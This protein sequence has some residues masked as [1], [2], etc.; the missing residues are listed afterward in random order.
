MKILETY[1]HNLLKENVD[2]VAQ[3]KFFKHDFVNHVNVI[4]SYIE[5][6]MLDKSLNYIDKLIGFTNEFD[7]SHI[8]GNTEIDIVLNNKISKIKAIG[9]E[10]EIMASLPE[11][12]EIDIFCLTT[13]LGNI[14]DNVY[15]ALIFTKDKR[16]LCDINI[17]DDNIHI[18]V[19]NTHCNEILCNGDTIL[20]TKID[21]SEHGVGLSSIRNCV[22]KCNGCIEISYDSFEFFIDISVP[23]VPN[24][25][26]I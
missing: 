10:I 26:K 20:S 23:Y 22:E 14:L 4:R 12:L 11:E 19:A 17:V 21:K 24:F 7:F 1:L 2:S 16:L 13:L 5:M 25:E 8:T 3:F 15:D 9:T 18:N 6:G